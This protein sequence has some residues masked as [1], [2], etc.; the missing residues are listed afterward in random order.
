MYKTLI[1]SYNNPDVDG[2]S[3]AFAYAELLQ[4]Q[5]LDAVA[6]IF[7]TLHPEAQF[8]LDKFNIGKIADAE[9]L[10]VDY[11][12]VILVDA[13]DPNDLTKSIEPNQV[14]E[15]IDHR[16]LHY[17]D[18]FINANTQIEQVGSCAT[19]IAEKFFNENIPISKESAVLLYSAII[20]NTIN[21]KNSV[22]T[23]RD[24]IMA[25]W[26]KQQLDLPE[27]YIHEMF[28][29]KSIFIK[30][31][32]ETILSDLKFQTFNNHRISIGQMEIVNAEK[33]IKDNLEEIQKALFEIKEEESLD[34][35]I[36]SL[37][38]LNLAKNLFVVIDDKT[39]DLLEKTLHIEFDNQIAQTDYIIM[40]KELNPKI[41]EELEK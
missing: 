36:L 1:T 14:I 34:Y 4:K 31:I 41:K 28:A 15:I 22:T 9:L 24:K 18:K 6:G 10:L 7:G 23:N 21:F 8:V 11:P 27:N 19:L 33:C 20:S 32:K 17:A 37:I 5:G 39:K 2:V 16:K 3:C 38:D 29:H 25:D 30:S 13:S 26:L 12:N 35:I 40:R